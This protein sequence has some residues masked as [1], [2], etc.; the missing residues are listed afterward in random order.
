M[1]ELFL[2]VVNMSIAAGWIVPAV[3]CLRFLLKKA[4]K[5][6]SVLLWSIVGVRLLCPF[7]IESIFSLI[8]SAETVSP[9]IMMDRTPEI[10]TGIPVLNDVVNPVIMDSFAPQ[11]IASANPLQILIPILSVVWLFGI[12]LLLLYTVISYLRLRRRVR[13]AVRHSGNI[14][15]CESV[16][17]PFVLGLWKP[18]IYLPFG[19]NGKDAAHV[20]AHE[21]A[22]IDRKDHL[23]KPL[24]FLLLT[25]YWF[26]PLLWVAYIFLCRD[27][28][29]ACDERVI[30][31]LDRDARADYS[32]ALLSCSVNRRMIAACPLAFGEV[33]V[34]GRV[35]SV[36]N[37]KKPAFWIIVAAIVLCVVSAV[38]FLTNPIRE[39]ASGVKRVTATGESADAVVLKIRYSAPTGG[40]SV[41]VVPEDEG[42]YCGDG[43]SAYDGSLGKYRIMVRFGD[44]DPSA[45]FAERYPA[46]EMAEL[47]N[48]PVQIRVKRVHPQD[49]GFVL[50]F[51]FD[52]PVSVTPV[53]QG[54]LSP[55][56]GTVKIRVTLSKEEETT[57]ADPSALA[58]LKEKY[59]E[60]FGLDASNGL[61]V[62]VWQF[63]KNHYSFGLLPHSEEERYWLSSELVT[64]QGVTVDEMRL[65][66]SAYVLKSD[67]IYVIPWQHPFSSYIPESYV[68]WEGEDPEEKRRAYIEHVREMLFGS[69]AQGAS[70]TVDGDGTMQNNISR[71]D[72]L[73]IAKEYW[74]Y[75]REEDGYVIEFGVN[76][77]APASVYVVLIRRFI[78]DHHYST[79]DEIWV[80]AVTGETVIPNG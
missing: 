21:Q 39:G 72:A 63:A 52:N 12:A 19:M 16:V 38:C 2:S 66:L 48:D 13:T 56:F 60:Y 53:E 70:G 80:D 27:I 51:G 8:P 35:R 18:R 76:D 3:L 4:P 25:V 24:G 71:S 26:H 11:P 79:V 37:Y 55:L 23:W 29:L 41:R 34:K 47:T 22:H 6:V 15:L 14:Y 30:R 75:W 32:E 28:E 65:I 64:L 45:S 62:Y 59:P 77:R 36:L 54:E 33:G 7:S 31:A 46:G 40:Y 61:D 20:V 57:A 74:N 44:T 50:Y 68:I 69:R 67:Q 49:H 42:E 78:S 1:T 5:W 43:M 10:N 17:S 9:N 73:E 58:A